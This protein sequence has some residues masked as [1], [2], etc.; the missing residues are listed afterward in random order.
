VD[1][2]TGVVT[3]IGPSTPYRSSGDCVVDKGQHVFMSS[4]DPDTHATTGDL[5]VLIDPLTAAP[6]LV[7]AIGF[8]HVFGLSASFGFLFA[9]TKEGHVLQIDP[10]TGAGTLLFTKTGTQFF[11]AANGD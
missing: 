11:G 7:G 10:G 6:T 5:F 1:R 9:V 3:E 8:P 2:G 4:P